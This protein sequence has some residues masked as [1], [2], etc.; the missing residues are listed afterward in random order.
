[1]HIK[2]ITKIYND[3]VCYIKMHNFTT[4]KHALRYSKLLKDSINDPLVTIK[5]TFYNKQDRKLRIE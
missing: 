5:V 1:M 4:K 3:R 2:V